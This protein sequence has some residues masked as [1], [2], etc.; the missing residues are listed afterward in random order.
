MRRRSVLA[1]SLAVTT[2]GVS[3]AGCSSGGGGNAGNG[4]GPGSD[5]GTPG[6][7]ASQG[8]T[9]PGTLRSTVDEL[10]LVSGRYTDTGIQGRFP[11]TVTVRNNG[12]QETNAEEYVYD[13]AVFDAGGSDITGGTSATADN[14]TIAPGETTEVL[15][16][17][18]VDGDP[19]DVASYEVTLNCDST[20][21][22]GVYCEQTTS[23]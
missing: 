5:G 21:A 10:E 9:V 23:S 1:R 16:T 6:G 13:Y 2:L 12:D 17:V 22:E 11:V 18:I 7:T 4:T 3:I 19:D 20:F 15:L 14:P 8:T